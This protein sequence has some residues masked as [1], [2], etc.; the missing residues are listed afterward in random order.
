MK[1][2]RMPC[3]WWSCWR[4]G[5]TTSCACALLPPAALSD[6]DCP[7]CHTSA[8]LTGECAGQVCRARA[9]EEQKQDGPAVLH[10]ACAPGARCT[11]RTPPPPPCPAQSISSHASDAFRESAVSSSA[12]VR[13]L[14][15]HGEQWQGVRRQCMWQVQRLCTRCTS[16]AL[17]TPLNKSLVQQ[18]DE[19][20]SIFGPPQAQP[21]HVTCGAGSDSQHQ[22]WTVHAC[23]LILC[24]QHK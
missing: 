19:V 22:R 9:K 10:A 16:C 7:Q 15:R 14:S 20:H 2:R 23:G 18:V 3:C 5:M 13:D 17:H 8:Q 21:R 11:A 12:P 24:T 4:P 1:F 6:A